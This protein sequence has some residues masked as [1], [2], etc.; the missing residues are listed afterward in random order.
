MRRGAGY[1]ARESVLHTLAEQ[2]A[3]LRR[4]CE[5]ATAIDAEAAPAA[6]EAAPQQAVA[7]GAALESPGA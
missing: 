5:A 4:H 1:R 2:D 3:W 7:G 6:E